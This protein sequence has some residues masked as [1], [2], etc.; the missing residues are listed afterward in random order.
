[1]KLLASPFLDLI[2]RTPAL[3]RSTIICVALALIA[4]VAEIAVALSLVPI[5]TS[6]GVGAGTDLVGFVSR[7]PPAAWLASCRSSAISVE[8]VKDRGTTVTLTFPIETSS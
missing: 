5:L 8:S 6:L 7:I 1:M 2:W 3:R 4:A